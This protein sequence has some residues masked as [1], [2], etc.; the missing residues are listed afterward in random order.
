MLSQRWAFA[1]DLDGRCEGALRFVAWLASRVPGFRWTAVH[2]ANVDTDAETRRTAE[3]RIREQWGRHGMQPHDGVDIVCA[4]NALSGLSQWL[5]SNAPDGIVV[6]RRAS[7]PGHPVATLG[8][9]VR[10]FLRLGPCPTLVVP[11]DYDHR[12]DRTSP[13]VAGLEDDATTDAVLDHLDEFATLLPAPKVAVRA[14]PAT[15]SMFGPGAAPN[16][17]ERRIRSLL[18]GRCAADYEIVA[19]ESSSPGHLVAEVADK[20]DAALILC[21][22][23][24]RGLLSRAARPSTCSTLAARSDRPVLVVPSH[25]GR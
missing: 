12:P 8:H 20:R 10:K 2:V 1:L 15:V 14:S 21:G 25:R 5:G 23:P 24:R 7:P 6:C 19:R 22:N 9:V 3:D 17:P 11:S 16:D 13:V 18:A 4:D